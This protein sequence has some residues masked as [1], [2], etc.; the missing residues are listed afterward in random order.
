MVFTARSNSQ[1]ARSERMLPV[2]AHSSPH[3][4]ESVNRNSM[5]SVLAIVVSQKAEIASRP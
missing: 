4:N 3:A 2:C 5:L 1:N